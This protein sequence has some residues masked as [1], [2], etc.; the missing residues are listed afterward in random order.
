MVFPA[1]NSSPGQTNERFKKAY[2]VNEAMPQRD[3]WHRRLD[4]VQQ[5]RRLVPFFEQQ[6][7]QPL[8]PPTEGGM[9]SF[10]M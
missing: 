7:P 9:N 1:F 3:L 4:Y 10:E 8:Y 5:Q 2:A 6:G